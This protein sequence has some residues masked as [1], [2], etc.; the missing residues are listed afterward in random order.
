MYADAYIP[1]ID[2]HGKFLSLNS[3]E[4]AAGDSIMETPEEDPI[5]HRTP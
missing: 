3:K 1:Y 4:I 2:I 5:Q